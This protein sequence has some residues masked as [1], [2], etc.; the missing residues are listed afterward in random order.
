MTHAIKQIW[1]QMS[2]LIHMRSRIKTIETIKKV[3]DAMRIIS[4]SAHS[5][6]KVKQEPLSNYIHTLTT[7]LAKVQQAT[8]SW[9]HE[10]L[11]PTS[12]HDHNPLIIFIGSQKGLCGSFNTQLSHF[13]SQYLNQ[14]K[15]Q[16]YHCAAIG[17]KAADFLSTNYPD[18]VVSIFPI[19]TASNFLTIAQQLTD[20][21]TSTLPIYT[22]VTIVSTV[23]KNFFVQ[24]PIL[25]HLIPFNPQHVTI[26]TQP[27]IEEYI[28]DEKPH[29]ILDK[30]AMHYIETQLQHLIFQ[31]LLS[32]H[33]ARFISMD[34]ST[35]NAINLLD[36]TKREYNKLRQAKITTEIAELT[37]SF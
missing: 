19:L 30:L 16:H 24:K 29:I 1:S 31:S 35:R 32:E 23:F 13:F 4:M 2:K 18:A 5:R 9:T 12:T 14:K 20:Q 10:R 26:H 34:N 33:A 25:T 3:T 28:W 37:G 22:S 11:M 17:K 15:M 8:P 27:Q 36:E 21:I 6:L 7:L